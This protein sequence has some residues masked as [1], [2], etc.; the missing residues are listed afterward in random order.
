MRC[1]HCGD[2]ID[3]VRSRAKILGTRVVR[4]CAS[5]CEPC[6]PTALDTA[7]AHAVPTLREPPTEGTAIQ[8]S[9]L[10][11]LFAVGAVACIGLATVAARNGEEAGSVA[12]KAAGATQG[13]LPP[14]ETRPRTELLSLTTSELELVEPP[15]DILTEGVSWVHPVV[16]SETQIPS[17]R[18]RLFRATRPGARPEECGRGHCGVDLDGPRGT[19]VVA[20]RDG[21][22][23]RVVSD[24]DARGGR[25]V[26]LFHEDIGLRT[27]Y[28]HIDEIA[29]DV[30]A[31][32]PV[33]AGQWLGTLGKTGIEHSEPHLHFTVRSVNDELRYV[34]P[35]PYLEAARVIELLD[36]RLAETD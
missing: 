16:G 6:Q 27:E 20:I 23:E 4:I 13:S 34:D 29:P 35:A 28:F 18:T 2:A 7:P 24:E 11:P 32:E 14:R 31:G 3:P 19:P 17:K 8:R 30:V 22:I 1:H 15:G 26:W 36:M 12:P 33:Q 9:Y 5:G 10:R 21:I 25:Y